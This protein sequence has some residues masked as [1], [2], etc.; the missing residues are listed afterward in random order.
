MNKIFKCKF[1][2]TLWM[3]ICEWRHHQVAFR[4]YLIWIKF[5]HR[6]SYFITSMPNIFQSTLV[7]RPP[8]KLRTGHFSITKH[9][10]WF[11]TKLKKS[12]FI[13]IICLIRLF[14]VHTNC[15][16]YPTNKK[17]YS[18]LE[19]GQTFKI[20]CCIKTCE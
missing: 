6:V 3:P 7:E 10:L 15:C 4:Q 5:V 9:Y 18:K 16:L 14:I 13:N 12:I 17:L 20:N 19:S 11:L 1:N 8:M 2:L